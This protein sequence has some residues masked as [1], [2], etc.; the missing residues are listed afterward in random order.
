MKRLFIAIKVVP[1]A[2]FIRNY[3]LFIRQMS[4]H[5]IAW[6]APE[7]MHMTLKFLG[8]TAEDQ[9]P[10]IE[11]AME[12]IVKEMSPL[13]FQFSRLGIFGSSYLPKV[14]WLGTTQPEKLSIMGSAVL[15]GLHQAGFPRDRQ[16]FVPHLTL[17]RIK[18]VE[19]KKM[20]QKTIDQF[21]NQ[22]VINGTIKELLLFHST[23]TTSGPNYQIIKSFILF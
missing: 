12:G 15:D 16:N 6:V 20:F 19:N 14:I 22:F 1:D 5:R 9:I 13:E 3:T 2:E 21:R 4:Y 10:L 7:V 11:K 18:K 17:G 23:L 8:S